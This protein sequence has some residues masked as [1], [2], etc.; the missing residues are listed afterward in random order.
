MLFYIKELGQAVKQG[1]FCSNRHPR[2]EIGYNVQP[3]RYAQIT[4]RAKY[5]AAYP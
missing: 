2:L 3:D 5:A 1:Q 4:D